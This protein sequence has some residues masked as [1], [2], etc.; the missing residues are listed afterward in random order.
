METYLLLTKKDYSFGVIT[1]ID[2]DTVYF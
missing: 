2:I 1:G